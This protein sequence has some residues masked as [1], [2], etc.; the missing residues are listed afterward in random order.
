MGRKGGAR[1]ADGGRCLLGVDVGGTFTD[2][3]YRDGGRLVA[4]KRPSTPDD[5]ARAVLDGIAERGWRPGEVV[6]GSTVATNALLTRSGARTAL[7]ATRGFRDT[8]AIGRQARPDL[9]A[10]H[11]VRPPPLVPDELRFEVGGR[12][13]ADGSV[14]EPLDEAGAVRALRAIADAGAEAL[15]ICLLF[16]FANPDHERRLAALAGGLGLHVSAS[17]EVLPEHREYER[18]STTAANAFVAPVT[19]RYL[20]A[21]ADGLAAAGGDGEG[22]APR[23]RVM[24][25]NGG[26]ASA[27]Q[28]GREAVRTVLSG[29]AGGV[30]GAFAAAAASGADRAITFD[31]GG[32]STD[33]GLCP[34]RILERNDLS[35]GGLPIRTPAVDVHT[36]GAGGGSI[37]WIDAGGALRVG[38]QSAG[39]DPGPA[40][41]GRGG[42]PTVTDAHA[43]L[44][45]LRPDRFLG[46]ALPLRRDRAARA[47]A[48]LAPAFGGDGTRAAQAVID[49]V[50]ANMV[51]ALRV[52]SVERG[53]DPAGFALVAFGGAGPLHA[54]DVAAELGVTT[55]IVPAVPGVLSAAGMVRADVTRDLARGLVRRVPADAVG[56]IG[57]LREAFAG[58]ER[59]ARA[60]L[61]A[62]GY[63][64][65]VRVE[66]SADLRY[67]GQSH[68]LTVPLGRSCSAASVRRA[69]AA[70]HLERFGHADPGR[71]AEI[72]VARVKARA[73]GPGA[74]ARIEHG[75]ARPA[76]GEET[77]RVVWDRPRR[78][79]ILDR[80]AVARSGVD[81]PAILTQPDTTILVPPGWRARPDGSA[82]GNLILRRQR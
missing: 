57:P 54:C 12:V 35:V 27:A 50:N 43:V 36:V 74:E 25:S 62:D 17:H 28:A 60:A 77:E 46:G 13:A 8:L 3:L 24:L 66:R 55:V 70:A 33:A 7:I 18:M 30:V 75:R 10:L 1:R 2:F 32:T 67:R 63:R 15:A 16:S 45:R 80:A 81:G 37:A 21:L 9:Y 44:G 41:Y 71:A 76:A 82:A 19:A 48:A 34:G 69:L 11:P 38:P 39:A 49:V 4:D 72:V 23:L 14:V 64:H 65:G 47:I 5:P 42:L 58:L 73:P 26:S 51:R 31:M 61:A 53:H 20:A 40:A 52:I 59:E 78:T 6:H 79:R 22:E 68:E 29:P 56:A